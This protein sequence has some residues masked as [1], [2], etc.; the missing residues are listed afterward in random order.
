MPSAMLETSEIF[1]HLEDALTK[2]VERFSYRHTIH[3]QA[4]AAQRGLTERKLSIA[5]A[6]GEAVYR[7]GLVFYILG[8]YNIPEE[9]EREASQLENTV[10]IVDEDSGMVLTCYRNSNPFKY[11]RRKGKVFRTTN[12]RAQPIAA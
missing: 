9:L 10:V 11:V 5:L 1:G 2:K 12:S 7:Q 4:R 3:S 8:R 6:H